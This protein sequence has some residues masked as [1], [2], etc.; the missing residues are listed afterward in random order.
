MV[1]GSPGGCLQ[2]DRLD[3]HVIH[4]A[5]DTD[6]RSNDELLFYVD[7]TRLAKLTGKEVSARQTELHQG[8][9]GTLHA[10]AVH[11]QPCLMLRSF[12]TFRFHRGMS[13]GSPCFKLLMYCSTREFTSTS[14]PYQKSEALP[15]ARS[16]QEAS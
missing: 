5:A 6:P 13:E 16:I 2:Q 10:M 4:E 15:K 7:L 3:G 12:S 8:P 11:Q 9:T 1:Q 14:W